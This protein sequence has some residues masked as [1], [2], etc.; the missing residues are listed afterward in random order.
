M[1]DDFELIVK[2]LPRYFPYINVYP[3][4]D[5]H[6]GSGEFDF[7]QWGKWKQVVMRD[8]FGYVVMIGDMLDNGLKCSKTNAFDATMSPF[9]QKIWLK[10]QLK[11]IAGKILGAVPGNHELRSKYVADDCPLYDVMAKLDIEDRYRDNMAFI[12]VSLG[13]K[14]KDR[15][16]SYT[17]ALAHGASRGKTDRFKYAIDGLDVFITGHTHQPESDFPSKIVIDSHNEKVT[18]QGFKHITVPSFQKFGGYVLRDMYLPQDNRIFPTIRL[19]GEE[20]GVEV[21]WTR[22]GN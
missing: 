19:S 16:F 18:M 13:E 4:G 17:M 2:K 1:K 11:P 20:K 3:L 8:E 5:L 9:D 6:I 21:L 14:N 7:D 12:K 22:T 15:Q 10:D